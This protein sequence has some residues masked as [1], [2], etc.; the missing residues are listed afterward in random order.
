MDTLFRWNLA[1]REQLGTLVPDVLPSH[2]P[3]AE[4]TLAARLLAAS[5]GSDLW[6]IGRSLERCFDY[7]SGALPDG[8]PDLAL[9]NIS[10]R[11]KSFDRLALRGELARIGLSPQV[12]Y[13]RSRPQALC[14]V[15]DSGDTMRILVTELA[16][17]TGDTVRDVPAVMRQLRIVGVVMQRK[18]SPN[19]ERWHQQA[20]WLRAF[21]EVAV[22]N[23]SLPRAAWSEVADRQAKLGT[24]NPP[25]RWGAP[26][27]PHEVRTREKLDAMARA[28]AVHEAAR[29][30]AERRALAGE[31]AK[32]KA[33]RFRWGRQLLAALT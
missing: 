27:T 23:V 33:P 17:W 21:P 29:D 6:F 3:N 25:G 26:L 9:V 32:T 28:L 22:E 7:L 15:I 12:L 1:R 31:L 16:R 4:R 20:E 8:E 10:L 18:P 5:G 2:P 30:P 24:W 19:A 11:F 14:D 13:R